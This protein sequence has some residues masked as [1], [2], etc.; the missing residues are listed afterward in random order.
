MVEGGH[1]DDD[2][3][4]AAQ[5]RRQC[6]LAD[7][8]VGRVGQDDGVRPQ[9]LAVSLEDGRQRV[10]ADLLLPL[11]EDRDA[12]REAAAVGPQRGEVRHDPG[13]VV[14]GTAAVEAAVALG[15]LERRAVPEVLAA[16]RLHVVV[17]VEHDRRG[18]LG[19]VDVP[20]HG[21]PSALAHDLDLEPLGAQQLGGGRRAGLDVGLVERVQRDARDPGQRL[22]V[23]AHGWHQPGHG[24]LDVGDLVGGQDV[25]SHGPEPSGAAGARRAACRRTPPDR[26]QLA[27]CLDATRR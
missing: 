14:G 4:Q 15:G 1:R 24:R 18:P 12:H 22:E 6:R 2:P 8:P 21:G 17:R 26:I 9:P 3:D 27:A 7:G 16:G 10:G 25:V 13:L 19:P 20:D 11:D 23:G 5:R